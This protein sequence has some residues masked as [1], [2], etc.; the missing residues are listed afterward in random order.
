MAGKTQK[1]GFLWGM[2]KVEAVPRGHEKVCPVTRVTPLYA[3]PSRVYTKV[4]DDS[5]YLGR[6]DAG[7]RE[8]PDTD[9][10]FDPKNNRFVYR[11]GRTEIWDDAVTE[12]VRV[13]LGRGRE[14]PAS[15]RASGVRRAIKMG[16]IA[17]E[18]FSYKQADLDAAMREE[19]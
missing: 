5:T 16:L 3:M 2:P 6:A 8:E 18:D 9:V 17:I 7:G 14:R 10:W 4:P 19:G 11:R 1:K 12:A 13:Q 15:P